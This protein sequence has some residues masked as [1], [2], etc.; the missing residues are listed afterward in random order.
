MLNI[1][2]VTISLE[3][4]AGYEKNEGKINVYNYNSPEKPVAY[5][6]VDKAHEITPYFSKEG[7]LLIWAQAFMD[8]SNQSYYGE[9]V[10]LYLDM[11]KW[12]LKRVPTYK[13][14]IHDI[15]WSPDGKHFIVISGFMPG[16]SVLFDKDCVPKY[17]FGKHHRN[18]IKWSPLGRFV[19][20]AGYGNL[21]GDM[22]IWDTFSLVKMGTCKSSSAVSCQWSPDGRKIM[23]GVLNPRLR[24]DN[25][26][27]IFKYNGESLNTVDFGHSELYEVLWRPGQY[28]DRP[29]SPSKKVEVKEEAKKVFRP[30]GSG[31]FAA[32]LK[33]DRGETNQG[34]FLNPNEFF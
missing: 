20:L 28:Q 24:V 12:W 31:A 5:K 25:N 32:Q 26:Y 34:R 8:K 7:N 1:L 11:N 30:K 14:P 10:L 18:T 13:G 2:I 33:K 21:S 6:I 23:T 27:R 15:S 3:K 19:C 9:H 4:S 16:G 22:E 17:E 29:P